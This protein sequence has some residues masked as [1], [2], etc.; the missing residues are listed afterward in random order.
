M[1]KLTA[2]KLVIVWDTSNNAAGLGSLLLLAYILAESAKPWNLIVVASF[3]CTD[4]AF[5]NIKTK[6]II[7]F[8]HEE[9]VSKL[10][11]KKNSMAKLSS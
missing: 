3:D 7:Y 9:Y 1:W 5:Q 6:P 4:H 10:K 11:T 8:T 2:I